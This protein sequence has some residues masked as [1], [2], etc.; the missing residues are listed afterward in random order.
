MQRM[1]TGKRIEKRGSSVY[2]FNRMVPIS[3][4]LFPT[5]FSEGWQ[6]IFDYAI[7]FAR[8]QGGKLYIL[9][10]VRK[11]HPEACLIPTLE[12]GPV[13]E[14]GI[15]VSIGGDPE[16]EEIRLKM[17]EAV[18]K[19]RRAGLTV[20]DLHAVGKPFVEILRIARE[21]EMDL[22]ILG[23]HEKTDFERRVLR[24]TIEKILHKA[25]CP[26]LVVSQHALNSRPATH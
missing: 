25:S 10:V 20:E 16:E 13:P 2:T 9:N 4:I 3:K 11:E 14:M 23:N 21:K 24:G 5:D 1:R 8:L 26:V 15:P 17:T 18:R 6:A 7:R 19:S 22:I 12:V